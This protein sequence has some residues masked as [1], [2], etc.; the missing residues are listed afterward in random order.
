MTILLGPF[1]SLLLLSQPPLC[2]RLSEIVISFLYVSLP[3]YTRFDF[4]LDFLFTAVIQPTNVGLGIQ[5]IWSK[6]QDFVSQNHLRIDLYPTGFVPLSILSS[7]I[8]ILSL[9][10]S[11]LSNAFRSALYFYMASASGQTYSMR[12]SYAIQNGV[13]FFLRFFLLLFSSL[14]SFPFLFLLFF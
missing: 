12:K 10:C 8:F 11:L 9:Y 2:G 1:L 5:H 6:D 3:M 7:F 13:P 4:C 14:F